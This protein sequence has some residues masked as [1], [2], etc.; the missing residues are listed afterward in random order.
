MKVHESTRK[1]RWLRKCTKVHDGAR[2]C[3]KVQVDTKVHDSVHVSARKCTEVHTKV[4]E[5]TRKS[6]KVKCAKV[7]GS[8]RKCTKVKCTKVHFC[9]DELNSNGSPLKCPDH[10]IRPLPP[11]TVSPLKFTLLQHIPGRVPGWGPPARPGPPPGTQQDIQRILRAS[12]P[13]KSPGQHSK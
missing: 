11:K 13:N 12:T 5:S 1:C 4:H 10:Q 8:T 2:K 6:T 9:P 7:R 3:T